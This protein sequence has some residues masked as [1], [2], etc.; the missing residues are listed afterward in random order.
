MR[1]GHRMGG[2]ARSEPASDTNVLDL[3]AS[4]YSVSAAR[5]VA[6]LELEYSGSSVDDAMKRFA[7]ALA[8]TLPGAHCAEW[9]RDVP[10]DPDRIRQ[11]IE[12]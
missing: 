2:P 9:N 11:S 7:S 3:S 8:Q 5:S 6:L 4:L 10:L 12:Q 1:G